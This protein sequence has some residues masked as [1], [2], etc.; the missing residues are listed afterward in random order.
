MDW[1]EKRMKELDYKGCRNCKHQ[2]EPL[3]GCEWLESGGDGRVHLICP[4][5]EKREA[6]MDEVEDGKIDLRKGI[7][8]TH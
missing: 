5:W 4:M 8:E 2:I 1:Y 3:R 6:K 7:D